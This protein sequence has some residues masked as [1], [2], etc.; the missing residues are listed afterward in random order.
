MRVK[1][2][3]HGEGFVTNSLQDH[4]HVVFDSGEVYQSSGDALRSLSKLARDDCSGQDLQRRDELL[5]LRWRH[6]RVQASMIRKL[7][8]R[9]PDSRL[10]PVGLAASLQESAHAHNAGR[11]PKNGPHSLAHVGRAV[12]SMFTAT[13]WTNRHAAAGNGGSSGNGSGD[14]HPNSNSR[15]SSD[16]SSSDSSSSDSSSEE[17]YSSDNYSSDGSASGGSGASQSAPGS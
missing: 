17:N 2:P 15:A 7:T 4:V 11:P 1:H 12:A 9:A 14:G 6:A 13:S 5:R 10:R 16:S 8:S 3:A